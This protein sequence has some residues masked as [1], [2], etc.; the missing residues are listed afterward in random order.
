MR[1]HSK[2]LAKA[3]H[4]MK[5]ILAIIIFIILAGAKWVDGWIGVWKMKP[6]PIV[7][8]RSKVP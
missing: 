6:T 1:I 8:Q 4:D 5:Q 7:Y 2:H 3:S